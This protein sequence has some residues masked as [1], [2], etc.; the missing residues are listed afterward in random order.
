MFI[1]N[2]GGFSDAI[3]HAFF[4]KVEILNKFKGQWIKGRG[5]TGGVGII[6]FSLKNTEGPSGCISPSSNAILLEIDNDTYE[7]DVNI[8]TVCY[9]LLR[10]SD[11]E[12]QYELV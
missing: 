9:Y 6:D 10:I 11:M 3:N 2:T 12:L 4:E 1:N 5:Q 8:Y 7:L